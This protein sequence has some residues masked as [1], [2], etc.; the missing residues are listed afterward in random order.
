MCK[1]DGNPHVYGVRAHRSKIPVRNCKAEED[2]TGRP[3]RAWE[4]GFHTIPRKPAPS[5]VGGFT[6]EH[7]VECGHATVPTSTLQRT[8]FAA[9]PAFTPGKML[10]R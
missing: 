6:P 2:V 3:A 10:K 4:S 1:R 8:S 7:R 9:A 5:R